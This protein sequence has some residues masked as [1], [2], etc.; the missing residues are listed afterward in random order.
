MSVVIDRPIRTFLGS[1]LLFCLVVFTLIDVRRVE[2]SS[3]E[4]TLETGQI[5]VVFRLAYGFRLPF[6][7]AYRLTWK[8]IERGDIVVFRHP[9]TGDEIVKRCIGVPGD[10]I[11]RTDGH[12]SVNG[13]ILD[14]RIEKVERI[15]TET[16][17][18]KKRIY[19]VG[20]DR[21]NSIDSR[22]YGLISTNSVIGRVFTLRRSA[23]PNPERVD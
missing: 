15:P 14:I 18:P 17:I 11:E 8:Q 21:P 1:A 10:T 20:D 19:V 16:T 12:L 22:Y 3:M 5:I 2:G 4:P 23:P 9:K 13:A 7:D 6:Q